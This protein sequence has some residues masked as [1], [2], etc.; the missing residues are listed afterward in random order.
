MSEQ[1]D[2]Q[3]R[4][5]RVTP[6]AVVGIVVGVLLIAFIALNR[7]TTDV[8]FVFFSAQTRIW[9]AL[10]TAAAAG[11]LVGLV[12]GRRHYRR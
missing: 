2:Q 12:V 11:L 3:A 10:A 1:P 5:L 4:N 6:R 7:D 9:V 8:S